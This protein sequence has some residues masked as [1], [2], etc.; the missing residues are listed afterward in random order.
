MFKYIQRLLAGKF[1]TICTEFPSTTFFRQKIWEHSLVQKFSPRKN[2]KHSILIKKKKRIPRR[3]FSEVCFLNFFF[4]TRWYLHLNT[5]ITSNMA[6]YR[7]FVIS[8]ATWKTLFSCLLFWFVSQ[9]IFDGNRSTFVTKF[10]TLKPIWS[11]KSF[12]LSLESSKW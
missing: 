9:D 6:I 10:R 5:L 2:F 1:E 3:L 11:F 7:L 4:C 8:N 12:S